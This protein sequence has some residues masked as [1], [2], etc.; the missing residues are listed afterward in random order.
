MAD[1]QTKVKGVTPVGIASYPYLNKPDTKFN[2]EGEF[3]VNLILGA[4]ETEEL[5]AKIDEMTEAQAAVV[6]AELEDKLAKAKTGADK[7]KLKKA[8]ENLA[9]NVPYEETVDDDGNPDGGYV[10][11]FKT[12]ATFKDQK[13]GKTVARTIKLFDAKRNPTTVAVFGG[14]KIKVAYEIAPYFVQATGAYGV[15]LRINA[16]QIIELAQGGGGNGASYGFDEEDGFESSGDAQS[17]PNENA[18]GG[19]EGDDEDF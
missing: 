7:A 5:R 15:S 10:L 16:V 12:K 14:S 13:T 17:A 6:R 11:R 3:K 19:S 1:K 18:E 4:E 8:I 2:T 9:A